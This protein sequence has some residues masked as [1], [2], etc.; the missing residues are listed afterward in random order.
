MALR[1]QKGEGGS[2]SCDKIYNKDDLPLT[3]REGFFMPATFSG[4]S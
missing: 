4:A 1:G 2:V 3:D